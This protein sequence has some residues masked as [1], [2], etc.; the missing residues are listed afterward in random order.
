MLSY[1]ADE[2]AIV[3]L[4]ACR[5]LPK[6]LQPKSLRSSPKLFSFD[7]NA[8]SQPASPLMKSR[9]YDSLYSRNQFLSLD[10]PNWKKTP[11]CW[12][13][14]DNKQSNISNF[15]EQSNGGLNTNR[16]KFITP[17]NNGHQGCEVSGTIYRSRRVIQ[18]SLCPL[19]REALRKDEEDQILENVLKDIKMKND[20]DSNKV[21]KNNLDLSASHSLSKKEDNFRPTHFRGDAMETS[22]SGLLFEVNLEKSG[23]KCFGFSL[24]TST[25]N[26]KKVIVI[27]ELHKGRETYFLIA[28]CHFYTLIL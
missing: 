13:T 8:R 2:S 7:G 10:E 5:H 11:S 19:L 4:K 28:K 18:E 1:R 12:S 27:K 25:R 6:A 23:N 22:K 16:A 26:G 3:K 17:P 21:H 9:Q 24:D 20:Q 15:V 14:K